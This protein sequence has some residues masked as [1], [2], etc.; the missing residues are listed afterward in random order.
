VPPADKAEAVSAA[1]TIVAQI[2][3]CTHRSALVI[4]PRHTSN[5]SDGREHA[6]LRWLL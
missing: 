2:L 3:R 4:Q 5:T 6:P 1:T